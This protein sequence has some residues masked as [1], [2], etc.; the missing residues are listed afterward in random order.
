MREKVYRNRLI[1]I[2]A[3]ANFFVYVVRFSVL[4][5]GPKFLTEARD[6]SY[7][8]AGWTVAIFEIFGIIGM[9]FAGWATDKFFAGRA[10]RTCVFCMLGTAV[11]M[12]VFYMLPNDIHPLVLIC[13]LAMADSA[14]TV[15]R[16]LSA[17]PQPIR[18]PRRLPRRQTDLRA[19]SDI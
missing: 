19:Y 17:S 12:T 10:H 15:R 7:S 18:L 9:L 5:W 11:F 16:L 13:V 6:M 14:S 3:F 8:Y 2:L 1:W 4:D